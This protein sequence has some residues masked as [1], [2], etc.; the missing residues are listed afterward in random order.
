[1]YSGKEWNTVHCQNKIPEPRHQVGT[2]KQLR[3]HLMGKMFSQELNHQQP[4]KGEIFLL[5]SLWIY[6]L[7]SRI[8]VKSHSRFLLKRVSIKKAGIHLCLFKYLVYRVFHIC[9]G[10]NRF[11]K[12]CYLQKH[13]I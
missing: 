3:E 5:K 2:Q 12:A 13:K 11:C 8:S 1:M 7:E 6:H 10:T 9:K 4:G